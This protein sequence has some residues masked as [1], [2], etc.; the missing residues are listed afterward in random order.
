MAFASKSPRV[1]TDAEKKLIR[2][3]FYKDLNKKPSLK[4]IQAWFEET[5]YYKIAFFL[6]LSLKLS[7]LDMIILMIRQILPF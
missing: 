6:S 3:F 4:T 1:I 5:H 2:D 7:P